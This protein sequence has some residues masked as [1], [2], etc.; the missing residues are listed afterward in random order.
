M[1][2]SFDRYAASRQASLQNGKNLA[3]RFIE[4]PAMKAL[5]PDLSGKRV[6][7][8]GCGTGEE[9]MILEEH[10]AKNIVG[11]D[12]SDESIRLAAKAYPAHTFAPG[13]MHRLDFANAT[14]DFVY[15]SLAVHYSQTPL[16]IYQEAFRVLKPG[17]IFQFS[18][19]HP[20]RWA[21]ESIVINGEATQVMGFGLGTSGSP[22]HLYGDYSNFAEHEAT[23]PNGQVEKVWIGPP[24]MHFSLLQEAGFTI[25][26]FN[27]TKPTDELCD[28]DEYYYNRCNRFPQFT[29]FVAKK[30]T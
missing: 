26:H 8:I 24:S 21:S 6:L 2:N 17:G 15:S 16:K 22:A 4:K 5:L 13:D 14:F 9:A 29:V 28:I 20:L 27:E 7:L 18:T 11:I 19:G 1:A 30:A 12:T 3:H 10:G 23:L 25:T